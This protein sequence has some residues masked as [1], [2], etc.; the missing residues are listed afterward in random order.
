MVLL[1]IILAFVAFIIIM[2]LITAI[3]AVAGL[4][5]AMNNLKR[6]PP[7]PTAREAEQGRVV[8]D[9]Q[10]CPHCGTYL[11]EALQNNRC[12]TCGKSL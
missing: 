4:R 7:S 8:F 11:S 1:Q 6:N 2:G 3:A 10:P 5:R 12:P 9:A